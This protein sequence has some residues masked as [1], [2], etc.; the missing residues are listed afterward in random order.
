MLSI[1]KLAYL[2]QAQNANASTD[3]STLDGEH[4]LEILGLF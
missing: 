2:A 3:D 4:V 1:G